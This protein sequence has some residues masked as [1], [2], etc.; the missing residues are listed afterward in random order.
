MDMMESGGGDEWY[1]LLSCGLH[2]TCR[3]IKILL[4]ESTVCDPRRHLVKVP[5][6]RWRVSS[7]Y[8]PCSHF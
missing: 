1:L 2:A 6:S 3:P 7:I 4:P 8:W 5:Y